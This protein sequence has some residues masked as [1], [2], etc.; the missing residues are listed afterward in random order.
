MSDPWLSRT[1]ILS[2]LFAPVGR[3]SGHGVDVLLW[4]VFVGLIAAEVFGLRNRSMAF[5]ETLMAALVL[6]AA[7]ALRKRAPFTALAL[8]CF[9]PVVLA[10]AGTMGVLDVFALAYV[11]PCPV[12]A[13]LAGRRSDRTAPLV[14]LVSTLA[15]VMLLFNALTWIRAGDLRETLTGVTDWAS[16]LLALVGAVVAPWLLG[17]YW[18]RFDELR[19]A[20]W[21]IAERM[22]LARDVDAERARLRE[23]S[24]IATDMHGALGNDL[25]LIGIRAA[26]LELTVGSDE[27][28]QAAA[29][30]RVA[31][32]E[33][34]LRLR[35]IIGVLRAETGDAVAGDSAEAPE[36]ESMQTES[37]DDGDERSAQCSAERAAEGA[38]ADVAVVVE[39][40]VGAGMAVTLIREGTAPAPGGPSG[41]LVHLVV[42]EALTNAARYAPGSQV[43]VRLLREEGA[44]SLRVTD[45]GCVSAGSDH[46]DA[47]NG[48]GLAELRALVEA[49]GGTFSAGRNGE[50]GFTVSTRIPDTASAPA[51]A[52]DPVPGARK[53]R[54][55]TE[56]ASRM[57]RARDRARRWLL[58][59]VVVPSALAAVFTSLGFGALW[60]V[61][62]NTVLPRSDYARMRVGDDQAAV[63]AHLPAFR[64]PPYKPTG[65]PPAP[66]GARCRYYLVVYENGL[67]PLYRLCF[68]DG[69]LVAKDVV[70]RQE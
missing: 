61:G 24:R 9:S 47:G 43:T 48:S 53:D 68:A 40:A 49:A 7:F 56:T 39:R 65:G 10:M 34:N 31:A 42:Q 3:R 32:H 41:R 28:R 5:V 38:E 26:A 66:P 22:E 14:T 62:V 55:R 8:A 51:A 18:R 33:A 30:L 2:R 12:L 23:R 4:T 19:T 54:V 25:A 11:L 17:R 21:E 57:R 35:E 37:A 29:E 45:T 67:P 59:A 20:G 36:T 70:H 16:G 63:E 46:G 64:Y 1:G 6:G 50:G 58:A 44:T 15:L 27:S 52:S 60:T 13:F 69:R